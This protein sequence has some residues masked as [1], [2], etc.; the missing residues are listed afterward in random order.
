MTEPFFSPAQRTLQATRQTTKLAD[1]L[2]EASVTSSISDDQARFVES[3]PLFF[4]ATVDAF[5]FPLAHTK[6]ARQGSFAC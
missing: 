1:R 3:R 2:L 6:A 4:L 5:G